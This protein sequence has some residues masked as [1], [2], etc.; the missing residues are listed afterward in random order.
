MEK[1]LENIIEKV[2]FKKYPYLYEV[3]V[4]DVMN[5]FESHSGT[6]FHCKLKSEKCLDEI[7]VKE[8]LKL[9]KEIKIL[10]SMIVLKK[11]FRE[12]SIS[13]FID[14]GNGKGYTF[15]YPYGYNP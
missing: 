5:H 10:F 2:I 9:N 14:C 13:C 6:T 1:I 15:E 4:E 3:E 7:G 11:G 12:P 8:L